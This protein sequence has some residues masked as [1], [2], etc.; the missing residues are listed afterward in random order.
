MPK[1]I[2][3]YLKRLVEASIRAGGDLERYTQI[4]A[5][6]TEKVAAARA[7]VEA[8]DR[9]I[10]KFDVRLVPDQIEPVRSHRYGGPPP[11]GG[12]DVAISGPLSPSI[13]VRSTPPAR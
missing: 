6:I 3:S 4:L 1:T 11:G 7:E 8:C 10:R 9:L 2:P 5:E 13:F 12:A